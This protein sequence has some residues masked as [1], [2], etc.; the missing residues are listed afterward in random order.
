VESKGTGGCAV[1]EK[2]MNE[3]GDVIMT[4]MEGLTAN[5]NWMT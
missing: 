5:V 3:K 4:S 1:E 2:G